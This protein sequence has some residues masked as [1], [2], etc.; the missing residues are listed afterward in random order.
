[1]THGRMCPAWTILAFLTACFA[2]CQQWSTYPPV[3]LTARLNRPAAEP[4]PTVIAQA[5]GY[6]RAQYLNGE[7]FPINLPKGVPAEVYDKVFEKLGGGRPME[8]PDEKA[9]HITEVRTRA[10]NAQVDMI[11]SRPD[12]VPQFVT[13]SLEHGVFEKWRVTSARPWAIRNVEVPEPNYV[14]ARPKPDNPKHEQ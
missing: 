9:I 5:I 7:E 1:M 6:A 2:G 13:L 8:R 14:P 4:V 10:L 3:E 11:Y 12:G